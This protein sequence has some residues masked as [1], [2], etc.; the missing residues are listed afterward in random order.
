ML[1]DYFEGKKVLDRYGIRSIESKYVESSEDAL[2][3]AG[4]GK[5]V[6]KLISEKQLHK[7]KAGL[8]KLDLSGHEAIAKAYR[9]LEAK[10]RALQP[11]GIIAQKMALGG[12]EIIIGGNEDPQFGKMVLLGLGGIYVEAFRDFALR[13]CPIT[14]Q[15]ALDMIDQ[16]KSRKV[17]T[18]G[19]EATG[20]IQDLLVKT[21]KLL[22]ENGDIKELDLNPVVV[23][24]DGYDVVDIRILK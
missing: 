19:G 5:L 16:L 13:L 4:E 3:F 1:L 6:L 23:R 24:P 18:Y 12:V 2:K 20:M 11:Y 8:V 17:V 7:S 21:S 9:E 14:R 10:G 22:Y 15:D